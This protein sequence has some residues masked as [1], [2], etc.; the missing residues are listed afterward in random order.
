MQPCKFEKNSWRICWTKVLISDVDKTTYPSFTADKLV[1][2]FVFVT[3]DETIVSGSDDNGYKLSV[4]TDGLT[5]NATLL[6]QNG[7]ELQN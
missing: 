1:K 2:E 6:D 5:L 4:S 3:P 7:K